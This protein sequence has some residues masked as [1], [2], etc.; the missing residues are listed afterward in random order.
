[1]YLI[2]EEGECSEV[3]GAVEIFVGTIASAVYAVECCLEASQICLSLAVHVSSVSDLKDSCHLSVV[4]YFVDYAVVA[5][6]QT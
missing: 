1:M 2:Y 5:N 6:T 4:V 3:V